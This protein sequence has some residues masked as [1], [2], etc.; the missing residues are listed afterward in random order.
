MQNGNHGG[1]NQPNLS[2]FMQAYQNSQERRHSTVEGIL[3]L[4]NNNKGRN[5]QNANGPNMVLPG[6]INN[7]TQS[8]QGFNN[9]NN[10]SW[11]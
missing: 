11:S 1:E 4:N 3:L 9:S 7:S 8:L 5:A 10:L 6:L 2:K